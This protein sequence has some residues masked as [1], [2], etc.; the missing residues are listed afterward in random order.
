MNRNIRL[1][2]FPTDTNWVQ[3]YV[4]EKK[5]YA[6]LFDDPSCY[7]IEEGR[8]SKLYIE[9]KA[10]YDRGWEFGED[11]PW[12]DDVVEFLESTPKRFGGEVDVE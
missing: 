6:K 1:T 2:T 7:G 4:R 8:V 11:H 3:G 10:S 9:G 5:F 12:V